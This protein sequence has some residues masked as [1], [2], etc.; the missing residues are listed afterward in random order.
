MK[1]LVKEMQTTLSFSMT[2][3]HSAG[4][5]LKLWHAGDG[6]AVCARGVQ[7]ARNKGKWNRAS[8]APKKEMINWLW[9]GWIEGGF[10][11]PTHAERSQLL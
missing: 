4:A 7:F 9:G 10:G 8:R 6:P 11:I 2:K 1:T 5:L 3:K